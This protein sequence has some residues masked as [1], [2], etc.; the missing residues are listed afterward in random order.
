MN[1]PAIASRVV[2]TIRMMAENHRGRVVRKNVMTALGKAQ[3]KQIF[4]VCNA[5]KY[6]PLSGDLPRHSEVLSSQH[7][8]CQAMSTENTNGESTP[9]AITSFSPA[10]SG[11]SSLRKC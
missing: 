8:P 7:L 6:A 10:R 3:G 5:Q 11:A 9:P 2:G 1:G 4:P